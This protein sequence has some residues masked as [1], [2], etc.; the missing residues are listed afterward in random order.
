MFG[1]VEL[2]LIVIL[3]VFQLMRMELKQMLR[4]E[5]VVVVEH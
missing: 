2:D 5:V 3:D 4:E 1:F